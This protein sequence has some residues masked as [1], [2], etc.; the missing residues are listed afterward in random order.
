MFSLQ[1]GAQLEMPGLNSSN[2]FSAGEFSHNPSDMN[3]MQSAAVSSRCSSTDTVLSSPDTEQT[4]GAS[5]TFAAESGSASDIIRAWGKQFTFGSTDSLD[6]EPPIH[7]PERRR[8]FSDPEVLARLQPTLPEYEK[9]DTSNLSS[10]SMS[11]SQDFTHRTKVRR[12][13]NA[14]KDETKHLI[15]TRGSQA[16]TPHQIGIKKIESTMSNTARGPLGVSGQE[17]QR[18]RSEGGGQNDPNDF[19]KVDYVI[20][21]NGHA[22]GMALSPDHRL[23]IIVTHCIVMQK[24]LIRQEPEKQFL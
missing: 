5:L 11:D 9:D 3:D 24:M 18:S 8:G 12:R 2:E 23:V 15:F 19:D 17:G 13:K 21:L 16:Y 6:D 4:S 22:I 10:S 14:V 1:E 7:Y 20:E